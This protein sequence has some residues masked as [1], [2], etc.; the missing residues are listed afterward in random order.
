MIDGCDVSEERHKLKEGTRPSYDE[1]ASLFA[2]LSVSGAMVGVLSVTPEYSD[3]YV[4]K[5]SLS[6]FPQPITALHKPEYVILAYHDL[7]DVCENVSLVLTEEMAKQ[8]ELE[9]RQQASSKLLV[10]ISSWQS[11]SFKHEISMPYRQCKS[12]PKLD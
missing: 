5:M 7:L 2:N 10:Q 1:M 12:I 9:T 6:I 8:V 11:Y 4:P 3:P